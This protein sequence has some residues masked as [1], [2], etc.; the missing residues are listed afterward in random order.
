VK[1]EGGKLFKKKMEDLKVKSKR[2]L[3]MWLMAIYSRSFNKFC[4]YIKRLIGAAETIFKI[5]SGFLYNVL[6]LFSS[7]ILYVTHFS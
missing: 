5:P 4:S 6:V 7:Q 1:V 2:F 3:Q